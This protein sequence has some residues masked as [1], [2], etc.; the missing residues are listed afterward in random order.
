[1]EE[2]SPT[3]PASEQDRRRAERTQEGGDG[4]TDGDDPWGP[5]AAPTDRG[6]TARRRSRQHHRPETI[7]GAAQDRAHPE[8]GVGIVSAEHDDEGRSREA[9]PA[10]N[11]PHQPPRT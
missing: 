4:G 3:P 2:K 1:M 9:Q 8:R 6:G 11:P 10:S 7:Q 5:T